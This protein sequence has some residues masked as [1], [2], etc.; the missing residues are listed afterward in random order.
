MDKKPYKTK[1]KSELLDQEKGGSELM[2]I[3]SH[4]GI[5]GNKRADVAAKNTLEEDIND[6]EL[7]PPQNLINWM[8][9]IDTKNRQ[10][11]WSHGENTMRFRKETIEWKDDST[12]LSKKKQEVISRLRKGY[13][14]A[15]HRHV[16]EKMPSPE[17]SFFGAT[18][19]ILWKCT[20]ATRNF[21]LPERNL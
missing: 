6:R 15:T 21:F 7:Y 4:S 20:E 1:Q 12:N 19:N 5:T 9:K 11:M 13:T 8:K 16:I 3:P 18:K 14:Q 2:W 17:C 10:E